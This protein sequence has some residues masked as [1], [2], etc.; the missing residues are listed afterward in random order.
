MR[1]AALVLIIGLVACK[2]SSETAQDAQVA[3]SP[4]PIE[5]APSSKKYAVVFVA[6]DDVLNVRAEPNASAAIVTTI[7]HDGKGVVAT[8]K[9]S[10]DWME[11]S[12]GDKQGWVNSRFLAEEVAFDE[13][14][15]QQKLDAFLNVVKAKGDLTPVVSARGLYVSYFGPLQHFAP[16]ALPGLLK[17]EE[18]KMWTG[19]ACDEPCDEGTFYEQVAAPL[20]DL[21]SKA[22][23]QIRAGV[24]QKGGNASADPPA[25]LSNFHFLSVFH[26][27][28][29][30]NDFLDWRTYGV[31]FD[32][33][34]GEPSVIA[35]VPD[36]WSP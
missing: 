36:Q 16:A 32:H 28:S 22:D 26:Q 1:T 4:K 21:W 19:P 30:A 3:P 25:G 15:A 2:S 13:A 5:P 8:G 31:Y 24:W 6:S 34:D 17:S 29:Q 18:K 10:D 35:L 12:S 14:K 33:R 20:V 27:G 9:R 23:K 7:T 11:V